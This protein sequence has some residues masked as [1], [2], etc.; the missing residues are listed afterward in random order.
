MGALKKWY[1]SIPLWCAIFLFAAAALLTASLISNRVTDAA[2]DRIAQI[3]LR[4]MLMQQP[5][6]DGDDTVY[7]STD[8]D[9]VELIYYKLDLVGMPESD[10][11]PYLL[12][13]TTIRV[14]P[15]LI[16]AGCLLAAALLLYYTKLKRPLALLFTAAAKISENDF[17]FSL[18]YAGQDEMAKLCG[19]FEKMRAALEESNRRMRQMIDERKQLNDAYTHDIRTPIAVLKGYT[20]ILAKFLPTGQLSPEKVLTT[21]STM[22]SHVER[23]EQFANSM[24]TAQKLA[25]V[26]LQ[27][28][29]V[30]A[31]DFAATLRDS[32]ELLSE[33]HN[34]ACDCT[35]ALQTDPLHLDPAAVTQVFENLLGNALRYAITR[36]TVQ[37]ESAEKVFLLRISDDGRGFTEKELQTAVQPYYSGETSEN[38]YHFGLGLYIS[39][40]LCEKHGGALT[41]ENTEAGGAVVT[42]RFA[43]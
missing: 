4:Y 10:V 29:A 7:Q 11:R 37:V 21:V 23:L 15:V 40:T 24:N 35:V 9:K 25:D 5:D 13:R 39:R 22:E 2:Y 8:G 30:A 12:Y 43:M 32:A 33:R 3:N 28:E 18:D 19:A 42:A 20:G 36:I 17:D 38:G 16:Y 41:L 6:E 34:L 1:R 27:K 31:E 26:V 14:A